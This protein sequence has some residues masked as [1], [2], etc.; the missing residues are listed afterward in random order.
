[1]PSFQKR[2]VAPGLGKLSKFKTSRAPAVYYFTAFRPACYI[3][4]LQSQSP[5]NHGKLGFGANMG[6]LEGGEGNEE[7]LGES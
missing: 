6:T 7:D 4:Q 3:A 5:P 2:T 1:M